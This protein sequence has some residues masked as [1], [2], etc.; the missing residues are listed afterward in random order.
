MKIMRIRIF[1]LNAIILLVFNNC[2]TKIDEPKTVRIAGKIDNIK[3][4]KPTIYNWNHSEELELNES[5]EFN[6]L[7]DIEDPTYLTISSYQL[8]SMINQ[9][10]YCKPGDSLYLSYNAQQSDFEKALLFSGDNELENN[11]LLKKKGIL[12]PYLKSETPYETNESVKKNV[13]KSDEEILSNLLE[14]EEKV[15]KEFSI[16]VKSNPRADFL[17]YEK[18]ATKGALASKI[19]RQMR[20]KRLLFTPGYYELVSPEK[21]INLANI[22]TIPSTEFSEIVKSIDLNNSK[23]YSLNN[24]GYIDYVIS[25]LRF[26]PPDYETESRKSEFH[27]LDISYFEK[28]FNKAEKYIKH[29]A[30]L[31]GYYYYQ[32]GSLIRTGKT[33][34]AKDLLN[35][36]TNEKW[37]K[38]FSQ[39]IDKK[40]MARAGTIDFPNF[41]AESAQGEIVSKEQFLGKYTYIDFWA[42]WCG[43]CIK[44]IPSLK[45]LEKDYHGKNI[46]FV[47]ISID[48]VKDKEK[49][50]KMVRDLEL[51]GIQLHID[52]D[53]YKAIKE[54]FK[55]KS[56]PRFVLLGPDGISIQTDA[57]RPSSMLIRRVLNNLLKE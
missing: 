25:A 30:V 33:G 20:N 41:N 42:T 11:F 37:I 9:R 8:G 49:W 38:K 18:F 32:I 1:I 17:Q 45:K 55:I 21:K 3:K 27:V 52:P 57:P 43:P 7:L 35:N 12:F 10:F 13:V 28:E 16:L 5:G 22:D 51:S 15:Y 2:N 29:P 39:E 34:I 23:L 26:L 4:G 14:I 36:L 44:E 48:Q 53:N 31:E 54:K 40:E 56:I 19:S 6:I 50:R 47:S 46:N 24:A